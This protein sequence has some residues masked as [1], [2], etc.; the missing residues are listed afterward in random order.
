AP[1]EMR[2]K[3]LIACPFPEKLN[4]EAVKQSVPFGDVELVVEKGGMLTKGLHYAALGEGDN[5]V[6]AL[7]S[8]T[9]YVP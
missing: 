5:I 1:D 4:K 7:A 6:V 3:L 8:L 9:V 2:V